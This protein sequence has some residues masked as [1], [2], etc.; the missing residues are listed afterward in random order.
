MEQGAAAVTTERL[1]TE[2][3]PQF[4]TFAAR[5]QQPNSTWN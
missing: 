1:S 4:V 5:L 2:L 3:T